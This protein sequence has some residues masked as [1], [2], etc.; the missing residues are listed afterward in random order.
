MKDIEYELKQMTGKELESGF[1][2]IRRVFGQF[3]APDCTPEGAA[4][5]T[6][7]YL[8]SEAVRAEFAQEKQEMFGAFA[9]GKLI[10]ISTISDKDRIAFLYVDG[11]SQ[12][13]GTGAE[14]L[15][16]AYDQVMLRGGAKITADVFP[17]AAA[18]FSAMGFVA[19]G[20]QYDLSGMPVIPMEFD[21]SLESPWQPWEEDK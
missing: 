18:F 7:S 9:D 2:L 17:R 13:Q 16:C 3:A 8:D 10:G 21:M 6:G 14:L 1:E 5:F 12:R 11:P 19:K 15:H 20:E 4:C